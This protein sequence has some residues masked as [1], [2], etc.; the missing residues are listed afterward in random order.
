MTKGRSPLKNPPLRNPGESLQEQ[1][2]ET[3]NDKAFPYIMVFVLAPVFALMEWG[4]YFFGSKPTPILLT[5][6]AIPAMLLSWRK[7]DKIKT[8]VRNLKRGLTAEKAVGQY[9]EQ[10]RAQGYQIFHDIPGESGGKKFN[11]DHV[12]IGPK[13]IFTIETKYAHKRDGQAKVRYN[14]EQI[15]IDGCKPERNPVI[16]AKAQAKWL[17]ERLQS[18]TGKNCFVQPV[19]VYPGWWVENNNA[20]NA[21][22]WVINEKALAAFI[23][24]QNGS[25][26]KEDIAATSDH[27][28]RYIQ[29]TLK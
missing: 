1:L 20:R 18:G 15:S 5:V 12:I 10:F 19:V 11:L 3:I 24:N 8:D 4:R 9:L 22:V 29:A 23:D 2:V 26:S 6:L 16:Q 17:F 14:G 13:G 28:S 27:L 25:L 7:L 21:K